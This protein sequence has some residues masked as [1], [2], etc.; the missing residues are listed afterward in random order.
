MTVQEM[1]RKLDSILENSRV[2]ILTTVD[3]NGYPKSRWMTPTLVPGRE[4]F[5]Y[6]VTSPAFAKTEEIQKHPQVGWLFQTKALDEVM[7]IQ[8]KINV[9]EN[10]ALRSEVQ[11]ALGRNLTIFWRVNP[12]EKDL[13]VLETVIEVITYFNPIKN[14]RG[15]V[16]V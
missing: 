16:V 9:I 13:V 10:P 7:T 5:L 3:E 8:G 1:L 11:E 6:A 15:K 14:E 12:R 4:G 2:G